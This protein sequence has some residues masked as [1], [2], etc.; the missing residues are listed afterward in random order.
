MK[1]YCGLSEFYYDYVKREN[2]YRVVPIDEVDWLIGRL[3]EE[4]YCVRELKNG[5]IIVRS[6]EE[7]EVSQKKRRAIQA[8]AASKFTKL[9]AAFP[10]EIVKQFAEACRKLGCTQ[11][12]VLTAVIEDTIDKAQTIDKS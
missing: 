8:Q 12:E 2:T 6:P 9:G 5:R 7:I 3:R 4:G 11:S 10:K 1:Q